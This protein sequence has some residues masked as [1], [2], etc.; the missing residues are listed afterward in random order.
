M[1]RIRSYLCHQNLLSKQAF[2]VSPLISVQSNNLFVLQYY[3]SEYN[4]YQEEN[5]TDEN[6]LRFGEDQGVSELPAFDGKQVP[7]ETNSSI[8]FRRN[9]NPGNDYYPTPSDRTSPTDKDY[10]QQGNDSYLEPTTQ[11]RTIA[12]NVSD[13]NAS[14]R[15]TTEINVPIKPRAPLRPPPPP[16]PS[17]TKRDNTGDSYV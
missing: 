9:R 12:G 11:P 16:P 14:S 7:V 2:E 15:T 6:V 10:S 8:N 4:H 5:A 17:T 13:D 3:R 1:S